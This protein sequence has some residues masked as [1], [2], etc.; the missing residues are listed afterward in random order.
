M[1][2]REQID[3]NLHWGPVVKCIFVARSFNDQARVGCL[4]TLQLLASV[5]SDLFLL[6]GRAEHC[7]AVLFLGTSE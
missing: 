6:G 4:T 2:L 7:H 3:D 5:V 1:S